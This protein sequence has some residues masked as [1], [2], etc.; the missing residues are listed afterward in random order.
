[1]LALSKENYPAL[2]GVVQLVGCCPAK[3]KVTSSIPGQGACLGC[4]FCP[5]VWCFYP[6]PSLLKKKKMNKVFLKIEKTE[7]KLLRP[8]NLF[9]NCHLRICTLILE[10]EEG[11][12][13]G[14]E[15]ETLVWRRNIDRLT[16]VCTL[17]GDHT[18]NLG[19]CPD[20]GSNPRP[21]CVPWPGSEPSTFCCMGWCSSQLSHPVRADPRIFN[22]PENYWSCQNIQNHNIISK[23]LIRLPTTIDSTCLSSITLWVL[24]S[25]PVQSLH[26]TNQNTES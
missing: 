16:P 10:R 5:Q 20:Q 2:T 6:S 23:V 7:R 26:V 17:T 8:K 15:R 1:M 25:H 14:R 13:W 11:G 22:S 18:C 3:Q 21:R 19:V 9:L 12:G 24:G 4:G